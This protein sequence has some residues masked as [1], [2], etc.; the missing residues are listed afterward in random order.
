MPTLTPSDVEG[1]ETKYVRGGAQWFIR[2]V[3]G[4]IDLFWVS[5]KFLIQSFQA[6]NTEFLLFQCQSMLRFHKNNKKGT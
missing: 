4:E 3:D 2:G 1:L 5:G 6:Y